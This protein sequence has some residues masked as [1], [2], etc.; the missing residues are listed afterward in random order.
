MEDFAVSDVPLSQMP[1]RFHVRAVAV[2]E[3]QFVPIQA[4]SDISQYLK[5]ALAFYDRFGEPDSKTQIQT[6]I[7]SGERKG[8]PIDYWYARDRCEITTCTFGVGDLPRVFVCQVNTDDNSLIVED[9]TSDLSLLPAA[10]RIRAVQRIRLTTIEPSI[11]VDDVETGFSG[12]TV[13]QIRHQHSMKVT[14]ARFVVFCKGIR[15]LHF[16]PT[17]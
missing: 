5:F 16:E 8:H 10:H 15:S 11:E 1:P 4:E 13:V 14:D 12:R 7:E 6:I 17:F 3:D 2:P 9:T